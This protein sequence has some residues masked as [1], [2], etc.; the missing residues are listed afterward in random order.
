MMPKKKMIKDAQGAGIAKPK[1]ESGIK[2]SNKSGGKLQFKTTF[3][4]AEYERWSTNL[5][6]PRRS[7]A[8]AET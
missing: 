2:S 6:S 1:G 3:N 5:Q 7:K 8:N 4:D